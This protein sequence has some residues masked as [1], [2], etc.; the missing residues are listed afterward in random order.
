MRGFDVEAEHLAGDIRIDAFAQRSKPVELVGLIDEHLRVFAAQFEAA[1]SS[2][3]VRFD[4]RDARIEVGRAGRGPSVPDAR[5]ERQARNA[6]DIPRGR[7]RPSDARSI[8]IPAETSRRDL[9]RR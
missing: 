9:L 7:C 1:H 8:S 4:Q 2:P 5:T 6:Q 3:S